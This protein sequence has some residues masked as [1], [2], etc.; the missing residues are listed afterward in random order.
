MLPDDY[1]VCVT[2]FERLDWLE[3]CLLSTRGVKNV[4][5]ATYGGSGGHKALVG[6]LRPD[7]RH[8]C[9]AEDFGCNRLWIQAVSMANTP[10]VHILHDDDCLSP[11][12]TEEILKADPEGT[13]LM[14]YGMV[15]G[16][17]FCNRNMNSLIPER[18]ESGSVVLPPVASTLPFEVYCTE[19]S[20]RFFYSPVTMMLHRDICLDCLNWCEVN[21]K[22]I[23]TR[24]GMMVGNDL[25]LLYWH[26][27]RFKT[28]RPIYKVLV[29][30][31]AWDGSETT[32]WI[33]GKNPKLAW[34]YKETRKILAGR[35][36][37][38]R[39]KKHA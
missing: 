20:D 3:K 7:A 10:Y 34:C 16:T 21:L 15:L 1:T 27:S 25:S 13:F 22:G 14:W 5:V 4:V 2:N 24:P 39:E 35:L 11:L 26:A 18:I 23:E 9:I 19:P 31:G 6:K 29:H 38:D 32:A 12:Y 33:R 36:P 17:N 37:K 8:Y 30:F 28:F